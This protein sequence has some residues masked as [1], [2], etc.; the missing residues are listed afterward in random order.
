MEQRRRKIEMVVRDTLRIQAEIL[1]E[2]FAPDKLRELSGFDFM[3]EVINIREQAGEQGDQF[4]DMAFEAVAKLLKDEKTRGFRLDIETD[5]T[6]AA[7][8][9]AEKERR[10]EFLTAVGGFMQQSLEVA[11][12]APQM[13]PLMGEMLL[14]GVR[15]FRAGRPL[16]SAIEDMVRQSKQQQEQQQGEEQPDPAAEAEAAK[17]QAE[18]EKAQADSQ[19]AQIKLQAAQGKAQTDQQGAQI[20]LATSQTKAQVDQQKMIAELEQ[21]QLQLQVALKKAEA[22]I[23]KL[24]IERTVARQKA[25]TAVA[26]GGNDSA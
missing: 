16:E 24:E 21:S 6:A 26:A 12:V 11:Q 22:D 2:R 20:K 13:V 9:D 5:S 19:G 15:G 10:V 23:E 18:G 17:A 3:P 25:L 8:Q 4:V 1:C 14:F 7:D